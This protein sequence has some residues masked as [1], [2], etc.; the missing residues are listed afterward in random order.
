MDFRVVYCMAEE[1][2]S[3]ILGFD[4][5]VGLQPFSFLLFCYLKMNL[6]HLFF[7]TF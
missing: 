1:K 7:N 2:L 3:L 4:G 5:W 6:L